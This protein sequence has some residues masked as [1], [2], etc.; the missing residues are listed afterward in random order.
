MNLK[1]F[2]VVAKA[3]APTIVRLESQIDTQIGDA[4]K[5]IKLIF[6]LLEDLQDRVN[7]LEQQQ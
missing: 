5:Q 3:I 1:D 7:K 4:Q 2:E 6:D